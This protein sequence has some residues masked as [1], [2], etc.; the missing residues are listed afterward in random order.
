MSSAGRRIRRSGRPERKS[1]NVVPAT[2]WSH[3]TLTFNITD[4]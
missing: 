1:R 2:E 4:S 3:Q